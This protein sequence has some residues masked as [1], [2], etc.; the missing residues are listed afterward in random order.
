MVLSLSHPVFI[1]IIQVLYISGGVWNQNG[2]I[3]FVVD[4]NLNVQ[5]YTFGFVLEN[6]GK[7]NQNGNAVFQVSD[8][9]TPHG[10]R[11]HAFS[12]S[13][14]FPLCVERTQP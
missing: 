3:S 2:D 14:F 6:G 8:G 5:G 7:W 9:I 11:S 4:G 13:S 1:F 10:S 12:S